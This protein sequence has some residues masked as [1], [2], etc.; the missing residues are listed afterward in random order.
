MGRAAIKSEIHLLLRTGLPLI[1]AYIAEYLMFVTTK[2]VAGKLG[3]HELA[4]VGIAGNLVFELLI[5]L[6]GILSIVGV[7][8]ARAEGAGNKS[9]AGRAVVQGMVISLGIGIPAMALVFQADRF[10]AWTG[11]DPIV[12]ALSSDYLKWLS[13]CVLPVLFFAV[14]R[15]FVSALARPKAVMVITVISV[16]VNYLL[17]EW[18]VHGGFGFP[19]M[20]LGGA[21]LATTIVTWLMFFALTFHAYRTSALRGYGVFKER[22]RIEP[23]ICREIFR[24]GIPVAGLVALEACLFVAASILS[25]RINAETLAAYEV[26]LAWVGIAFVTALGLAEA[27]MVR[28]AHGMGANDYSTARRSGLVGMALGITTLTVLVVVPLVFA[29]G[30]ADMFIDPDQPNADIVRKMVFGFLAIA[31]IFQVFDGLQAIAARALRGMNDNIA[32]LWIAS[33]GYW[34]LGIGGGSYLAF[35]LDMGGAGIWWGMAMGL[36]GTATLLAWRFH[37]KS[38]SLLSA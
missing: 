25:G 31:A 13:G 24:L 2:I 14:L 36:T 19:G 16:I 9:D 17:T 11:Q 10:L 28:V 12:A 21:G 30:I 1:A 37:Q 8:C 27:T 35:N 4:T 20:G 6:M 18:L 26:T 7:L 32:P 34:V 5:I 23:D 33:F 15:N 22:W 3:Y 29:E 38:A